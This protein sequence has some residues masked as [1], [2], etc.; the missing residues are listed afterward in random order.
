MDVPTLLTA[1]EAAAV[2]RVGRW[3]IWTWMRQG[4]LPATKPGK[5]CLI[6]QEDLSVL[7]DPRRGPVKVA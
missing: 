5:G 7:L 4:K 2:A 3:T 6:R 1:D